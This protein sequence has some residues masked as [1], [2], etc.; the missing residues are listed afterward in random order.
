MKRLE[1]QFRRKVRQWIITAVIAQGFIVIGWITVQDFVAKLQFFIDNEWAKSM[2]ALVSMPV[3]SSIALFMIE[4]FYRKGWRSRNR[5]IDFTGE[6]RFDAEVQHFIVDPMFTSTSPSSPDPPE[7]IVG[8]HLFGCLFIDQTAGSIVVRRARTYEK[9][10][11]KCVGM[12]KSTS[13]RLSESGDEIRL[14]YVVHRTNLHDRHN[15]LGD[16]GIMKLDVF[17]QESET[18]SRPL[19]LVGTFHDS[20]GTGRVPCHG[21]I[22][23]SR[24]IPGT[25]KSEVKN[26]H[27]ADPD[28]LFRSHYTSQPQNPNPG[29]FKRALARMYG[30]RRVEVH[31]KQ[32]P[33]AAS[34]TRD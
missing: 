21:T 13:C 26:F 34:S 28:I 31:I 12:W 30:H 32:D 29:F 9:K 7:S 24:C 11:R 23:L 3:L 27:D 19:K 16:A 25:G 22:T 20:L 4:R 6:W 8:T 14:S 2:L 10:L 15:W 18:N 17:D 33:T 5:E 1:D